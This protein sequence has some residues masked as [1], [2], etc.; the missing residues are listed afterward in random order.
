MFVFP[1]K[2]DVIYVLHRRYGFSSVS[3]KISSSNSAINNI[4]YDGATFVP[5]AIPRFCFKVFFPKSKNI[6]LKNSLSKRCF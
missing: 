6:V 5:V 1:I 2:K 4:L 3:L